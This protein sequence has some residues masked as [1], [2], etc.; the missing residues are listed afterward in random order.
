M[1]EFRFS[2]WHPTSF[3]QD[4]HAQKSCESLYLVNMHD[5][6]WKK[7]QNS[8]KDFSYDISAGDTFLGGWPNV[9]K[10]GNVHKAQKEGSVNCQLTHEDQPGKNL[11][12]LKLLRYRKIIFFYNYITIL[13]FTD[14]IVNVM[15]PKIYMFIL[16]SM[17]LIWYLYNII[18][19]EII[20]SVHRLH[21]VHLARKM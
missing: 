15:I 16:F 12:L 13:H 2:K 6:V 7:I 1:C 21:E 8:S 10:F 9:F 18:I 19:L 3:E 5:F 17:A 4:I 11:D 14:R 20:I